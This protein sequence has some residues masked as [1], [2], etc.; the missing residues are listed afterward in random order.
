MNLWSIISEMCNQMDCNW[1]RSPIRFVCKSY[2]KSYGKSYTNSYTSWQPTSV[3]RRKATN[4]W[5]IRN[6]ILIAK[7]HFWL[8]NRTSL[9]VA[10]LLIFKSDFWFRCFLG[11]MTLAYSIFQ[12][13]CCGAGAYF[14][15]TLRRYIF[16]VDLFS[17]GARGVTQLGKYFI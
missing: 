15:L 1:C 3:R 6:K 2:F 7:K 17:R 4:S 8:V 14:H 13:S 10:F 16:L 11:N 12:C 5:N 9:N